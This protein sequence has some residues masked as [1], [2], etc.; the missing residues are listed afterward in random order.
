M[1]E[2]LINCLQSFLKA[3]RQNNT[4]SSSFFSRTFWKW[5]D[6]CLQPY[7]KHWFAFLHQEC[8]NT[9][10][11]RNVVGGMNKNRQIDEQLRKNEIALRDDWQFRIKRTVPCRIF[12]MCA[13]LRRVSAACN[14]IVKKG[15]AFL[16]CGNHSK[17]CLRNELIHLLQKQKNKKFIGDCVISKD[18]TLLPPRGHTHSSSL[19][20]NFFTISAHDWNVNGDFT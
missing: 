3:F 18:K 9:M 16:K 11:I 2:L 7:V 15:P 17:N 4:Q 20:F 10:T 6:F 5:Q 19:F 1:K 8:K 13:L 14:K 12:A